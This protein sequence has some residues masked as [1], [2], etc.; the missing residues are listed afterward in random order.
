VSRVPVAVWAVAVYVILAVVVFASLIAGAGIL[1]DDWSFAEVF[2]GFSQDRSVLSVGWH[3]IDTNGGDRPVGFFILGV[4]Y[5]VL[6][7]HQSAYIVVLGLVTLVVALLLFAILRQ[8]RMP[9]VPAIGIGALSMLI[10]VSDA[11][12]FWPAAASANISLAFLLGGVSIALWG[13]GHR[14]SRAYVSH[15]VALCLYA[16]SCLVYEAPLALLPFLCLAYLARAGWPAWRTIA[17]RA[18]ADWALTLALIVYIHA[19]TLKS[20]EGSADVPHRVA[21][22]VG[23]AIQIF[24][25]LGTS[26]GAPVGSVRVSSIVSRGA[27]LASAAIVVAG[28]IVLRKTPSRD[29]RRYLSRWLLTAGAGVFVIALGH[30]TLIVVTGYVPLGVGIDNRVNVVAAVGYIVATVGL[31]MVLAGVVLRGR[32]TPQLAGV[33]AAVLCAGL[34]GVYLQRLRDHKSDYVQAHTLQQATLERF[35]EIRKP[36]P[37]TRIFS[38]HTPAESAPGVPVWNA[39]WSLTGALRIM[40]HDASIRA[41]PQGTMTDLQ[42]RDDGVQPVGALYDSTW[43]TRYGRAMLIDG[44]TGDVAWPADP[45]ACSRLRERWF[46]PFA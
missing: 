25:S 33:W 24:A 31:G 28:V 22:I 10:P 3:A 35:A 13:I 15:A 43:L 39:T 16:A 44:A 20:S 11:V 27:L 5:R 34:G 19:H 29:L 18:V 8:L 17:P 12:R 9:T 30:A 40:W 38:L 45:A 42:C 14:R 37:D 23:E 21:T 4:L 36:P 6:G 26:V 41:A 7:L 46:K 32:I 1:H 2:W